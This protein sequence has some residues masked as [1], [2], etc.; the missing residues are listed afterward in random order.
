M[1][2]TGSTLGG[3]NRATKSLGGFTEPTTTECKHCA[4]SITGELQLRSH[5]VANRAV[6]LADRLLGAAADRLLGAAPEADQTVGQ[7]AGGGY[8]KD[9]AEASIRARDA[10][11]AA[12]DA[13]DRL[14]RAL[15]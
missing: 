8:L 14:E 10:L 1:A 2:L 15:P 6:A 5:Q 4:F 7:L 13:I 3:V 12:L 11:D 9:M